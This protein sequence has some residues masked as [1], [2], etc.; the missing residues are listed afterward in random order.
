MTTSSNFRVTYTPGTAAT[1][2][3][4]PR[5]PLGMARGPAPDPT[6]DFVPYCDESTPADSTNAATSS[7]TRSRAPRA[8][9]EV[10]RLVREFNLTEMWSASY[11]TQP[12]QERLAEDVT[13]FNRRLRRHFR[14]RLLVIEHGG[15][16]GH[17]HVALP[18]DSVKIDLSAMWP[19]GGVGVPNLDIA[20]GID[21]LDR[22]GIYMT[23]EFDRAPRGR[24]RYLVDRKH[25][26]LPRKITFT[27]FSL[28]DA[29]ERVRTM[30]ETRP[31]VPVE[32]PFGT[33]IE[34]KD[35]A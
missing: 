17:L 2:Y 9:N 1:L 5:T 22:I 27:A 8:R 21:A 30:G 16:R 15:G 4:Q 35:A 19:H 11:A 20:S 14:H 12:S 13:R 34:F 6:A 18:L 7:R 33:F 23:K 10:R 29:L 3:L 32:H 24:H 25:M 31:P 26:A 28:Q